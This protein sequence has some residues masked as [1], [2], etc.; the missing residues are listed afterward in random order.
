MA[1]NKDKPCR[2]GNHRF[3]RIHNKVHI[4]L[5]SE[6]ILLEGVIGFQNRIHGFEILILQIFKENSDGIDYE[7]EK[8]CGAANFCG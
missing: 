6:Y 1:F 3:N 2:S 4:I 7:R 5:A 8:E